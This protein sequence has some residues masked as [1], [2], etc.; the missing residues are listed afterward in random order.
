MI[1][2]RDKD[3]LEAKLVK[4]GRKQLTYPIKDLAEW[5]CERYKVPVINIHYDILKFD[6]RPRL[7]IALEHEEDKFKFKD[8][9]SNYL[10][11]RQAAIAG[12]W[13]TLV[14][15]SS[16]E[17]RDGETLYTKDT[18]YSTDNV[19][20]VFSGFDRCAKSEA[21]SAIPKEA[22]EKLQQKINSSGDTLWLIDRFDC[23]VTY[24][25]YT[26]TQAA[27]FKKEQ[28]QQRLAAA[29]YELLKP[30]DEFG[31]FKKETF[32]VH[33]DSKEKLDRVCNG[34]LMNYYR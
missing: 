24:F 5:V 26:E 6:N 19:L 12:Q 30:Y 20:V 27:H 4:Q 31:Y 28:H 15:E 11:D 10:C 34:S 13:R 9:W 33:V 2:H 22:I 16:R 7:N 1:T 3:Y 25:F 14:Y 32:R 8:H 23:G 29:Y 17:T 21:N 18:R